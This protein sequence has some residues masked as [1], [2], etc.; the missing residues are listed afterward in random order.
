[1][2]MENPYCGVGSNSPSQR[3]DP[4]DREKVVTWLFEYCSGLANP[5]SFRCRW[6]MIA[7]CGWW[8]RSSSDGGLFSLFVAQVLGSTSNKIMKISFLQF[9]K[10]N[11][12]G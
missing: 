3:Y 8:K 7:V 1:M 5:A 9:H 2:E 4:H 11:E 12:K 6:R 10:L